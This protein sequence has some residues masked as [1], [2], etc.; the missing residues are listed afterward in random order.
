MLLDVFSLCFN[1]TLF[2]TNV[3]LQQRSLHYLRITLHYFMKDSTLFYERGLC[4]PTIRCDSVHSQSGAML[5]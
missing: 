5:N 1:K 3:L 4:V 2:S